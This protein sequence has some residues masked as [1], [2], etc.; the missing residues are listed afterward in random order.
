MYYFNT[1]TKNLNFEEC[2]ITYFQLKETK[3]L[4]DRHKDINT[5]QTIPIR[6]A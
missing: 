3:E 5:L 6:A 4:L 1:K 2:Q